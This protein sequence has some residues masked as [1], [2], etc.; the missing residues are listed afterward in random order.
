MDLG[1]IANRFWHA[2]GLTQDVRV[3]KEPAC[4][5]ATVEAK[6]API[7]F[8]RGIDF[9]VTFRG[10]SGLIDVDVMD[11]DVFDRL[12]KGERV[13]LCYTITRR[14]LFDYAPPDFDAMLLVETEIIGY[15]FVSAERL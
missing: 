4:E 5:E 13:K 15:K 9:M 14:N 12:K 7:G 3:I 8:P 1:E 2:L 6:D 11:I 10:E